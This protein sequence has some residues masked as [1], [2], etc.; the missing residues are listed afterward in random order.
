[1]EAYLQQLGEPLTPAQAGQAV[2]DLVTGDAHAQD[3]YLLT[4]AGLRRLT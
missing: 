2:V 3:A 4:A 1:V